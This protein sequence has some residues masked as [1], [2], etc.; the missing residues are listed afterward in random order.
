MKKVFELLQDLVALRAARGARLMQSLR[1]SACQPLALLPIVCL[2]RMSSSIGVYIFTQ[3]LMIVNYLTL[4]LQC[5]C[6]HTGSD[7]T[8]D[9]FEH[10]RA[11]NILEFGANLA[12][13]L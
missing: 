6:P 4:R 1:L 8:G 5:L 11:I 3:R 10:K 12:N 7:S 13:Q 2:S 9:W